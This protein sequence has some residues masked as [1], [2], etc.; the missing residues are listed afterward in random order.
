MSIFQGT[1]AQIESINNKVD[2]V[3]SAST[4]NEYPSAKAVYELA[5]KI[6]TVAQGGTGAT[7]A[8]DARA[9]LG[10]DMYVYRNSTTTTM[11]GMIQNNFASFPNGPILILGTKSEAGRYAWGYKNGN[12]GKFFCN[13]SGTN[14][15]TIY[16]STDG[17]STMTTTKLTAS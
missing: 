14:E 5:S 7:T 1:A 2:S 8:A 15:I 16:S 17:F 12:Y 11:S 3:T 13:Y 6:P 10:L 9:N 4:S